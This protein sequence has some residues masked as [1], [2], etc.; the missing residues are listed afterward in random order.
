LTLISYLSEIVLQPGVTPDNNRI[1]TIRLIDHNPENLIVDHALTVFS[2]VYD[3]TIITPEPNQL[4][5]GEIVVFD[6]RGL[7]ARHLARMGLSSLR[8]FIRYMVDAHPLR[9][10]QV[11]VVNSNSL[12]DKLMMM[13]RPFLGARAVKTIH[14]HLPQSTTLYEYVPREL[15]PEEFGGINGSIKTLRQYWIKRTEAHR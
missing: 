2:M 6:P 14:F 5:D 7:S 1:L 13:M 15:L 8:C 4:A 10:K 12:L 11:H 9:I 3:T